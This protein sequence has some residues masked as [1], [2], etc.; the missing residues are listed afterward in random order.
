MTYQAELV[1]DLQA[2]LGEGPHWDESLEIL[3]WVDIQGKKLHAFDPNTEENSTFQFDQYVSAVVPGKAGRFLLAMENG[4]YQYDIH[5]ND[6]CFIANPEESL[7]NNRFNDGKCDP[8]G[9]FWAGTMAMD[10]K[11]GQG[12]LYR[13]DPNKKIT[14]M[15]DNV[16]ISNGLAWSPDKKKMYFIDT[17]TKEI[18][19][20]EYDD[21]NGD[22]SYQETTI[23]IPDGMGNPDGMT[24]DQEGMLWVAH[25]GGARVTRWNPST[26]KLL[27]QVQVPAKNV[28]SCAFGGKNLDELYITTAK[29][30]LSESELSEYPGSGGLFKVKT[31]V[32]GMRA[33]RFE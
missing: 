19:T 17:P 18:T 1:L 32:K 25:W 23:K 11:L 2:T 3:Y 5:Q 21:E 9:R 14:K 20:F 24:I 30:G 13:L 29:I 16:S 27:D 31:D 4:I 12:N 8:S 28:T 10:G 26:G 33:Y 7:P 22:I 6:L 15:L